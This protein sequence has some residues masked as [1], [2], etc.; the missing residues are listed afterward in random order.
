[1]VSTKLRSIALGLLIGLGLPL[2]HDVQT[3]SR[4]TR[5]GMSAPELLSTDVGQFQA[6]NDQVALRR[7]VDRI[8]ESQL[9]ALRA[10]RPGA[11]EQDVEQVLGSTYRRLGGLGM[12][13]V[14]LA[15]SP[16]PVTDRRLDAGDLLLVHLA[17]QAEAFGARISRTYPVSGTF[18]PEQRDLYF[19]VL[20]ALRAGAS[21]ARLGAR[22]SDIEGTIV[23][24]FKSSLLRLGLI[25]DSATEEYRRWYWEDYVDLLVDPTPPDPEIEKILRAPKLTREDIEKLQN[26]D[27]H[28]N[29]ALELGMAFQI[30]VGISTWE[31]DGVAREPENFVLM[32]KVGPTYERYKNIRVKLAAPFLLTASDVEHL[33]S[34]VPWTVEDLERALIAN[35]R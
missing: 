15:S 35:R 25:T 30:E 11:S 7:A 17:G 16:R 23:Q 18:R 12:M 24:V 29:W 1:V 14:S 26:I 20:E 34:Q 19:L 13:S 6:A 10:I 27:T 31:G 4:E 2:G 9:A 3:V 33:S 8:A 22:R 21:A 32:K 5:P 28:R